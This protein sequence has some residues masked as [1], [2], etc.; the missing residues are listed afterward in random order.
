MKL[1]RA[2]N[3]IHKK[4]VDGLIA[5][6]T[7]RHLEQ[8]ASILG[9]K[10]VIFVSQDDKARVNIGVCAANKQRPLLMHL[11][12]R[13]S[14]PDHDWVVASK[15]KFIPSVYGLMKIE[16]N[17]LGN[18]NSI[19]YTGPTYVAIRSGKHSSSTAFSHARDLENMM[20]MDK[21]APFLKNGTAVKPILIITVDGGPD[22][23]PR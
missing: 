17:G 3:D 15:R 14:L 2:S 16:E 21:F 23:N 5:T 4:H 9:P 18:P 7:I 13:V 6:S 1:L 8:I 20:S 19:T 10:E 22:E 12:Y 11:D